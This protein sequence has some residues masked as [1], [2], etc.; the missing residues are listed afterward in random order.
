M[1]GQHFKR[2][3]PYLGYMF[4]F[5]EACGFTRDG[6]GTE[7]GDSTGNPTKSRGCQ[8]FILSRVWCCKNGIPIYYSNILVRPVVLR[9]LWVPYPAKIS[10]TQQNHV[11]FSIENNIEVSS[12]RMILLCGDQRVIFQNKV[13]HVLRSCKTSSWHSI[14]NC[15]WKIRYYIVYG[16]YYFSKPVTRSLSAVLDSKWNKKHT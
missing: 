10:Y 6:A 8:R 9:D 1:H 13:R 4:S 14:G 3:Q 2:S 16:R 12:P 15:H 7:W 11:N 5:H